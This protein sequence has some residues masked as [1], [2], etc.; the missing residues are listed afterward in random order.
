MLEATDYS[1]TVP[2]AY[3]YVTGCDAEMYQ[4]LECG[5]FSGREDIPIRRVLREQT[6]EAVLAESGL[7]EL[8]GAQSPP[9]II[10]EEPPP[11]LQLRSLTRLQRTL[12]HLTLRLLQKVF[13][14]EVVC[15]RRALAHVRMCILATIGE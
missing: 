9:R 5:G 12:P 6:P 14:L 1:V 13:V 2:I 7:N 15:T 4:A 3:M 8:I 11:L 10:V